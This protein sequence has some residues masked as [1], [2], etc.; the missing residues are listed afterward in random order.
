MSIVAN[1]YLS[2]NFAPVLEEVT[3]TDL[4]ITGTLPDVL[5][6]RYL[7]N[8]PNPVTPPDAETYHWFIGTGMVHGLRLRDGRAEWY[9]NRWVRNQDVAAALGEAWPGG[10]EPHGGFDS[11]PNTNVIGHA[12]RTFAIVEAG[13]RP[14]ELTYDLD[15]VGSCDFGGT[16]PGGYTAHPKLDPR[17]GELHA[18]AYYWGWD[19]VQYIV[20]SPEGVVT[21]T[22]NVAVK[23]S[24]MMHD[25]SLT[26]GNVVIYDMPVTF[27]LEVAASGSGFPYLWDD[28]YGAR[29]GVM[30]RAGGAADVRWFDVDPCYVFHP[31]NGYDD[32]DRVVLDVVRHP[33]MFDKVQNGPDDGKPSLWR[34]T[35]DT[36]S[37]S[38]HEVQLDDQAVEFPR[39]DERLVS[40]PHR[41]GYAATFGSTMASLD[42]DVDGLLKYD[43]QTG[44]SE[45]HSF[46][47]NSG[48]AEGVFVPSGE[49]AAEDDGY[50]VALVYVPERDASD[51]VVLAAQDF[52]ADPVATVHLPVRVPFGFHGNWVPDTP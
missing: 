32:G 47:A 18:M 38:V 11:A 6:G 20:V 42:Q 40:L 29:L 5:Q 10:A 37:G 49:G 34:W 30:P 45:M 31:M 44:A 28:D 16:L 39:V 14:Y 43:L 15:T 17:T 35:I 33:R 46:G 51:L 2:G 23:G 19:Y 8:G 36:A 26:Q 7:R 25:F 41:Y 27:N 13:S 3:V 12:G 9:R 48:A 1:R 50:V 4:P 24:P 21:R 22:E 52:T